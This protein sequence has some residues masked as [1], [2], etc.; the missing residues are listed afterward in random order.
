MRPE[1]MDTSFDRAKILYV[2]GI[3]LGVAA[4]FYFGFRI[5]E[6]LSPTTTSTVLFL[7]FVAFLLGA[8]Y[9]ENESLDT[10]FYALS[11]GLYLVFVAYVLSTYDLGDGGVFV[12]LAGSSVLF[13]ALGYS[14]SKG[15]FE[16][17][18]RSATVG[19]VV[20]IVVA[21]GLLAFDA[22]GAQPTYSHDFQDTAEVP[23]SIRSQVVVGETT[24]ENPFALSRSA[25][26]PHVEACVYT[27]DRKRVSARHTDA[28]YSLLLA[29]GETR[30]F[31]VTVGGD[32]FFDRETEELHEAFEGREAT[33]VE[34]ADGC[35]ESADEPKVVVVTDG[36]NSEIPIPP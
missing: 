10:V 25:E 11:A 3:L 18:R 8:L 29:G 13:V 23:D 35:P 4:A 19:L 6:D 32:G 36:G 31:N 27:P 15:L 5:L 22:T 24:V 33:P 17:N 9:A 14:L 7:S 16:L 2:V 30:S 34:V 12:L 1:N 21:L 26:L 28:P 20:V